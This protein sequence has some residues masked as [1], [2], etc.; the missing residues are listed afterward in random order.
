MNPKEYKKLSLEV[1]KYRAEH[2]EINLKDDTPKE[3]WDMSVLL[4]NCREHCELTKVAGYCPCFHT[5]KI[6]EWA[7][8]ADPSSAS[9]AAKQIIKQLQKWNP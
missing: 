5:N 9:K 6:M 3:I 4:W 2:P 8:A 1:W 7:T